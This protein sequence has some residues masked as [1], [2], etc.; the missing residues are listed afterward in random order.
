M[1]NPYSPPAKLLTRPEPP[2]W[3]VVWWSGPLGPGGKPYSFAAIHVAGQGW[4]LTGQWT[5]PAT[6]PEVLQLVAGAPMYA[7]VTWAPL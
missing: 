1:N 7:A 2:P 5:A 6:W 4:Y 3:T